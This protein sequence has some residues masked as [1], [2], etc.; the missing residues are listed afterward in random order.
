MLRF[1][2]LA[3][4]CSSRQSCQSF[5]SVFHFLVELILCVG[6]FFLDNQTI[7]SHLLGSSV[8]SAVVSIGRIG[9]RVGFLVGQRDGRSF[10]VVAAVQPESFLFLARQIEDRLS[11]IPS[12]G[13]SV[14][15]FLLANFQGT[16]V[17]VGWYCASFCFSPF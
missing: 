6:R 1:F 3:S 17:F 14:G 15:S 11:T 12:I 4:P 16:G 10:L 5:L 2:L 13:W 8:G 7:D 9:R